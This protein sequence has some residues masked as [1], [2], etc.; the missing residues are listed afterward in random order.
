[1]I[2]SWRAA[3]GTQV[4]LLVEFQIPVSKDVTADSPHNQWNR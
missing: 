1:M 3:L 2:I 4:A